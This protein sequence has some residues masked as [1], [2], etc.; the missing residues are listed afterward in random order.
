MRDTGPTAALEPIVRGLTAAGKTLR[1]YPPTSPIPRD[2]VQSAVN[3]LAAYLSSE[4]VLSFRVV[5]DGLASGGATVAPGAPGATELADALRDHGIQEL[6]FT[7]GVSAD[8]LLVFLGAV[9]EKPGDVGGRG[10]LA[11]VIAAAG[12]EAVRVS[13]VSLTVVDPMSDAREDDADEFLRQLASDPN[14][15]GA[16]L[17]VA[18]R[19]DPVALAGSLADLARAAGPENIQ[20]LADSL[21]AA[22]KAQ[23]QDARDS[24]VGVA[25]DPGT[26]RDLIG[27]VF[28]RM[29][30]GDVAHTLTD[31]AYGRNMLSMS[32][33]LAK[34]PLAERMNEVLEQVRHLLPEIGHSAKE[35]AFLEHMLEVRAGDRAEAS[36]ADAEPG[37]RQVAELAVVDADQIAG[38]RQDVEQAAGRADESAVATLLTLLDQQD[39]FALYCRTLDSLAGMV[40]SLIERGRLALAARVVGE[41]GAR[42]SRAHQPWPDLTGRLRSAIADATSR[43]SMKALIAAVA[44]DAQGTRPAQEIV[45]QAGDT[46]AGVFIE[47]ALALKPD[48]LAVAEAIAG[49]RLVDMLVAAAPRVQWFSVAPLAARLVAEPDL[50]SRAAVETLVK[51]PD[52]QSRRETAAGLATTGGPA[53]FEH[54]AVLMRDPSAEVA[55]AAI[56]AV[57]R[58]GEPG[59]RHLGTRLDELDID[60]K[61]FPAAREILGALARSSDAAAPA[62]LERLAS[63]RAIIKRGHFAEV[64]DLARQAMAQRSSTGT[65][66]RT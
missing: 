33:A 55:I 63:R 52:A 9:L 35:M 11:A 34:L 12:V 3:A 5:R 47:E 66:G 13:E 31:G 1:L 29:P 2:A 61:D 16:W 62:I 64:N 50:R 10:G 54:L 40:P 57:G 58:L 15:V 18:A 44:A 8:D 4:P 20:A 7:P 65:G 23:D 49:R 17:G 53:A 39:D 25:M 21:G 19:S 28:S 46:A 41:L 32:A 51:R 45:K 26:A 59:A 24:L 37:Y 36:L 14:R 60:G 22:M 56:R 48:G 6:D 27:R 42:E 38:A 30:A 43:R